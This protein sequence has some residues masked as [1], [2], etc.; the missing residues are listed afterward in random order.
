MR[1]GLICIVLTALC[2]LASAAPP[3][4]VLILADDMSYSDLGCYGSEIDTPVR[5]ALAANGLR[6][7][8]FHNAA[9][10]CPTR[11]SLLTGL[12]PHEAG[13]GHMVYRDRGPG[14]RGRTVGVLHIRL[15]RWTNRRARPAITG[16]K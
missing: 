3:N 15:A 8:D 12:Y 1:A 2:G 5:D 7:T 13:V 4:I 14:Y 10:C 11:A 6:Y 16:P 9:R